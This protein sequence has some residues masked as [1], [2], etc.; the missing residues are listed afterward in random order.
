[1]VQTLNLRFNTP[2]LYQSS[3]RCLN[4]PQENTK[5]KT[6]AEELNCADSVTNLQRNQLK[7]AFIAL[8]GWAHIAQTATVN[9][10]H[11][12]IATATA[13]VRKHNLLIV[14]TTWPEPRNLWTRKYNFILQQKSGDKACLQ[15]LQKHEKCWTNIVT[16]SKRKVTCLGLLCLTA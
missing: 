5:T 13:D 15:I 12:I 14:S 6:K 7:V 2:W 9:I 10:N 16:C 4:L 3:N 8:Y 11:C 1:M